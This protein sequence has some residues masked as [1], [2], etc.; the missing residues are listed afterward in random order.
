MNKL[1]RTVILLEKIGKEACGLLAR[2]TLGYL[3]VADIQMVNLGFEKSML[4]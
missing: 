3:M 4:E 2:V 1:K